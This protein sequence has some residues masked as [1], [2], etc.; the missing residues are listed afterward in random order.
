MLAH[1]ALAPVVW[2]FSGLGSSLVVPKTQAVLLK[3]VAPDRLHVG[4]RQFP[5]V[6]VVA[7]DRF[8]PVF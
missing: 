4:G 1:G 3:K 5:G 7:G 6:E 8:S 2:R